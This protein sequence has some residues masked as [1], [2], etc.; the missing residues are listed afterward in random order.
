L[1]INK[2]LFYKLS[3][4]TAGDSFT[5]QSGAA[6]A[7]KDADTG[8]NCTRTY[9][10]AWWYMHRGGCHLSDLNGVYHHGTHKSFAD[11]INWKTWKGYNY[12]LKSTLMKIRRRPF[13]L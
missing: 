10:G 7:T 9:K 5:Y 3:L 8:K 13:E 1:L 6:F 11:G 4:G 2:H 12:S